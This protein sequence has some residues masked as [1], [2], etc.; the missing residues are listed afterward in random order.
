MAHHLVPLKGGKRGQFSKA[1]TGTV[2]QW[3]KAHTSAR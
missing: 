1:T 2:T 3:C